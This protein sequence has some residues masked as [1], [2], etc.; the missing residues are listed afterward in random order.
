MTLQTC[1]FVSIGKE[2]LWKQVKQVGAKKLKAELDTWQNME[3]RS[4]EF[5]RLTEKN[6][7]RKKSKLCCVGGKCSR[8]TTKCGY[9]L[10]SLIIGVHL[11]MLGEDG[12]D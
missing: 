7:S 4:K 12:D 5:K 3:V 11:P 1:P 6:A 9:G 2:G 10:R 8:D